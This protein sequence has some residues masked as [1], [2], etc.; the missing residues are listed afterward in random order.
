MAAHIEI[1]NL[2]STIKE[3]MLIAMSPVGCLNINDFNII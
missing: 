3:S 2:I 1:I